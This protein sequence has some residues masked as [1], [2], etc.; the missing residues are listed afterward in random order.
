[1]HSFFWNVSLEKLK[2]FVLFCFCRSQTVALATLVLVLIVVDL[3]Q[4]SSFLCRLFH[5]YLTNKLL[6][7]LQW[8]ICIYS[9]VLINPSHLHLHLGHLADAFIQSDLQ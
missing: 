5:V 2:M 9:A 7:V 8:F 4:R 3:A 1:M 6:L